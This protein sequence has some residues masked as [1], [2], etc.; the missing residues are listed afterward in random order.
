MSKS[1]D[2]LTHNFLE[3]SKLLLDEFNVNERLPCQ[4][5]KLIRSTRKLNKP[6]QQF[7]S[8]A[9]YCAFLNSSY[10]LRYALSHIILSSKLNAFSFP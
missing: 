4:S 3:Y 7:F 9:F 2:P 6:A 10:Y 1:I 8:S 5:N